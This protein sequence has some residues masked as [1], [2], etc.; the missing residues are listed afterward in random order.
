MAATGMRAPRRLPPGVLA[1]S[2][3][4]RMACRSCYSDIPE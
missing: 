3:P 1:A 2:S 4:E